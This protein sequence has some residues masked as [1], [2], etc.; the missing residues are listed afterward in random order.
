M[1]FLKPV[2]LLALCCF[3][4]SPLA[5][6]QE[7]QGSLGSINDLQMTKD[8]GRI[9]SLISSVKSLRHKHEDSGIRQYRRLLN[10]SRKIG[11]TDGVAR[12]LTGLGLFYMDK[13]DFSKSLALYQAA[14]PYCRS[15]RFGNGVLLPGLYNNMAAL[16]GNRGINDSAIHFYLKSLAEVEQRQIKD[17]NLI[18]LL[19]SN[20]GGR[21]INNRKYDQSLFYLEKG[22]TMARQSGNMPM[23]AK[24]YTNKSTLY[25]DKK[26]FLKCR[27]YSHQALEI[28][29]TV[30]DPATKASA[31][32][33]IA[34]SYLDE[35]QPATALT[36][37]SRIPEDTANSTGVLLARA[38]TGMAASYLSMGQ[39]GNAEEYYLLAEG[40]AK[41]HGLVSVI[42]E[43]YNAMVDLYRRQRSFEKALAYRDLHVRISDSLANSER[44]DA[45][46]ALEVRYR[47]AEKDKDLAQKKLDLAQNEISIRR[48]NNLIIFVGTF[49]LFVSGLLLFLYRGKQQ[50]ERIRLVK[51]DK[52]REVAQ[53][54]ATMDGEERERERIARELHD[55]IMV[56]FSSVGMNLSATLN[57]VGLADSNDF[58]EIMQQ[59]EEATKD[60]RK[61][62]HNLMPDVLLREGLAEAG[63]YFCKNLQRS[64]GVAIDFIIVGE[65]PAISSEYELMLY[66]MIQE[67]L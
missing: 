48:K 30:R 62:A 65:M 13:G 32:S 56:Q 61:S 1:W 19:Y 24:I 22:E 9:S 60:L 35:D 63:H 26:E 18:L 31:I 8:T 12:S 34:R 54:K 3:F 67:L 58:E 55:G 43:C 27:A 53:L 66:R 2:I 21:M 64:A 46:N 44:T 57:R 40:L 5:Y 41:K 16:Y 28:F 33:N 25:G 7:L 29:K 39:L 51:M 59:L 20:L 42:K 36:W 6:G 49:A 4:H 14:E 50:K 45:L 38:Y 11:Y 47:T 23:L 15:A 10:W 17:T 52:E 37:Y